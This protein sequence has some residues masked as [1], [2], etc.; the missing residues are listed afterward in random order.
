M[1]RLNL[2]YPERIEKYIA[3]LDSF[4]WI[5]FI[6]IDDP[7]WPLPW[8]MPDGEAIGIPIIHFR[9]KPGS[10][11]FGR[12]ELQSVIPL[13]DVLNKTLIDLLATTDTMGFPSRYTVNMAKQGSLETVPGAIWGFQAEGAGVIPNDFE[14]GEFLA[15][16]PEKL[17][18]TCEFFVQQIA[19]VSRTPQYLFQIG[20]EVPSGEALK[21]AESG[22]VHKAGQRKVNFGNS[23]EDTIFMGLRIQSAFG[24]TPTGWDGESCPSAVWADSETR[25]EKSHLETLEAKSRLGVPQR[26]LWREMGYD[27]DQIEQ[28]EADQKDEAVAQNS[29]GAEIVRSFQRGEGRV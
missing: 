27:A 8:V 3:E 6:E 14:V 24:D 13:Q 12:S 7:I 11:D 1:A 29:V 22:L 19:G 17:I 4:A 25:N 15:A 5:P 18:S 16:D 9:N 2:Y 21:T 23:W 20:G 28:M 10:D 26:Q